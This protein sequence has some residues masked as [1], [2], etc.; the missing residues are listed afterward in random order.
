MLAKRNNREYPK[1]N[2]GSIIREKYDTNK[3]NAKLMH[4]IKVK[5]NYGLL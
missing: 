4:A 3:R 1:R 2:G 5:T